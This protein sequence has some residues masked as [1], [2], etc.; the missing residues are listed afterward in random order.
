MLYLLPIESLLVGMHVVDITV[1]WYKHDKLLSQEG[2][3][4][5]IEH[6]E[7]IRAAGYTEAYISLKKSLPGTL[8]PGIEELLRPLA[9]D[10]FA[11]TPFESTAPLLEECDLAKVIYADSLALSRKI[12]QDA[13]RGV[14]DV[15][16]ARPCIE[17]IYG[18][19]DRNHDALI[20]LS[21]LRKQDEY[22]YTH[23]INV[24]IFSILLA[25]VLGAN[26]EQT[27]NIGLGALFH[28]FGKYYI[29][30]EI[31]NAPRKLTSEEFAVMQKHPQ[32]GAQALANLDPPIPLLEQI[33][34]EHHE[35]FDGS[36][37]PLG[38]SK[39][40][41]ST[42]G[43]L[44]SLTDVFDALTS[45]RVYKNPFPLSQALSIIYSQRGEHFPPIMVDQ[46]IRILG[47]FPFGTT[48]KLSDGRVGIV[49]QSTRESALRPTVRI[50]FD[51]RGR[52]V[53]PYEVDLTV[54]KESKTVSSVPPQSLDIDP[55]VELNLPRK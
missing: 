25:K 17:G 43:A 44:V 20:G 10:P 19:L 9:H 12:E 37:Y 31:I 11:F 51:H 46:F 21:K 38:L 23:S 27:L 8:P 6:L 54:E 47:V 2:V 45:K 26:E 53:I 14:I 4:S 22:T 49:S 32:L 28:D 1:Q 3:I 35:K 5:S 18:S 52:R 24:S 55:A 36:G 29:P 33:A 13:R 16:G 40:G 34:Q 30:S 39:G 42:A 41:I 50:L 7:A 15:E 48:V